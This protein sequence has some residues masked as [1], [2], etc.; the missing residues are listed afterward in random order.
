MTTDM[1]LIVYG[2]LM[3]KTGMD[4]HLATRESITEPFKGHAAIE[5]TVSAES[6]LYPAISPDGLEILFV[7]S[8]ANPMIW[9]TRRSDLATPFGPPE[10]WSICK[11]D[12]QTSRVGTPQYVSQNEVVFSRI[13]PA[14]GGRT[15]WSC[16]RQSGTTFSPPMLYASP[17]GSPTVFFN[18]DG[19]RAYYGGI[20]DGF[21]FLWRDRLDAPFSTP[22][23]LLNG[24][25]TGPFDGTIWVSP[26]EDVV[27]YCSP[28]IGKKFGSAHKLWMIGFQ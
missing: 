6:E 3:E 1:K 22:Q 15:L 12:D 27:F 9:M 25:V 10:E 16:M 28:G 21:Y 23:P 13:D 2:R 5:A 4:L 20:Q 19:R 7:R 14:K 24:A 26:K 17:K 11:S 8:D 18:A